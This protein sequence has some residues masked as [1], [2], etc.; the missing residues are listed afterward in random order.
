MEQLQSH[1]WLTASSY[2]GKYFR[3]SSYIR[4]PFLIYDFAT[5]PLWISLYMRKIWFTFLSVHPQCLF[6]LLAKL[7]ALMKKCGWW[8]FNMLWTILALLWHLPQ[9]SIDPIFARP[10]HCPPVST[11]LN[12]LWQL[13]RWP[14]WPL[15]AAPLSKPPLSPWLLTP[16]HSPPW[17]IA[18]T[19]G[20]PLWL[21]SLFNL[22][23]LKKLSLFEVENAL[24]KAPFFCLRWPV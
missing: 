12:H 24:N 6:S 9:N 2:L 15:S 19:P 17:P 1:I 23:F 18:L 3:I 20:P 16:F 7:T 22:L 14:P 10:F 21:P 4:K 11:F 13:F 8:F 5:A